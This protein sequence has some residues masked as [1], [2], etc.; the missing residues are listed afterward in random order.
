MAYR[1]KEKQKARARKHYQK[2]KEKFRLRALKWWQNHP[3]QYL[4]NGARQ[5]AKVKGKE[6]SITLDDIVIPEICRYLKI[7]LTIFNP[8]EK[9][10][11]GYC[12]DSQISID[13]ID[14]TKGYIPGNI[15][16]ISCLA[17]RMKNSATKEQL[18][19]FAQSILD[20]EDGTSISDVFND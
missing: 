16:I 6:F 15:E 2:N 8:Y 1:N 7:P 3:K 17:N 19:Q 20:E 5:N 14:S 9:R 11:A 10:G 12:R 13:R 4:L 18:I